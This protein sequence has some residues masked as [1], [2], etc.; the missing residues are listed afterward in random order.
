MFFKCYYIES[1]ELLLLDEVIIDL[2]YEEGKH[3]VTKRNTFFFMCNVFGP[4]T[5]WQSR[6]FILITKSHTKVYFS[7]ENFIKE[8]IASKS[9]VMAINCSNVSTSMNKDKLDIMY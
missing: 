9:D 6:N 8:C 4:H 2:F 5:I 3:D 7:C 1:I